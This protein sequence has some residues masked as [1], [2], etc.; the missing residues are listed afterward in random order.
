MAHL[1]GLQLAQRLRLLRLCRGVRSMH[2]CHDE[3]DRPPLQCGRLSAWSMSN[4]MTG[5]PACTPAATLFMGQ[6]RIARKELPAMQ[7]P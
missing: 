7:V 6:A 1:G 3:V 5:D 4:I 2:S